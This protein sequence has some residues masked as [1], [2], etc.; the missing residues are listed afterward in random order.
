[1]NAVLSKPQVEFLQGQILA[2]EEIVKPGAYD[3][4]EVLWRTRAILRVV[5][6]TIETALRK[7]TFRGY[8]FTLFD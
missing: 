6:L 3:A 2:L 5:K 8:D 1:M 7:D 4:S